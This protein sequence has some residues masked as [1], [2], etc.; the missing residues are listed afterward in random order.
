MTVDGTIA[1]GIK[2]RMLVIL[3]SYANI[4]SYK[5]WIHSRWFRQIFQHSR[6]SELRKTDSAVRPHFGDRARVRKPRP[7]SAI[8]RYFSNPDK[9]HQTIPAEWKQQPDFSDREEFSYPDRLN[10]AGKFINDSDKFRRSR[11]ISEMRT[12]GTM[13]Q[14]WSMQPDWRQD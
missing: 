10:D 4:L 3:H 9:I 13:R 6:Q 14:K 5:R 1:G 7:N 11:R 12:D 2:L 8:Q